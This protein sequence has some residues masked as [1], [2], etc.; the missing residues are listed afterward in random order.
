MIDPPDSAAG[1]SAVDGLARRI[2]GS[3]SARAWLDACLARIGEREPTIQAWVSR[4]AERTRAAA[5]GIDAVSSDAPLAGLPIGVKDVIDVAG[6]PTG[7]NSPLEAGRTAN[8]TAKVVQRLEAAGAI[9][10]GKTVT[11]EYAFTEP[12]PTRNPHDLTRTPGGSSSGSAAAVADFHVPIALTT[13][14]GG[15]TIR[16]AA[17]CGI[18]GYKPPYGWMPSEG[19]HYLAPSLDAIGLHARTVAD[20][21]R[22]AAIMEDRVF[23]S[24]LSEA[25]RFAL[26]RPAPAETEPAMTQAITDAVGALRAAG[27]GVRETDL[28]AFSNELDTAH[29][30]IMA[31]EVARSFSSFNAGRRAQLSESLRAFIARGERITGDELATAHAIVARAKAKLSAHSGEILIG[32][33]APGEAPVGLASTGSSI[34]NRPWSLLHVGAITVPIATGPNG[35]PLGLQLVDPAPGGENLISAAALAEQAFAQMQ[36][37]S[38]GRAA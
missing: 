30:V 17:Y 18:V 33:P 26:L 14:T 9:V 11:T 27:A 29:R 12:G 31:V 16:P 4:D 32:P 2:S 6:W 37:H 15:S 28:P 8:A 24:V 1:V 22:V 35:M 7:C 21:A 5:D 3:L 23:A 19:L 13:Q 34:F 20:V 36:S 25:P 10:V 38:S